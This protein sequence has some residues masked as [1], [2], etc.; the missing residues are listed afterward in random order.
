VIGATEAGELIGPTKTLALLLRPATALNVKQMLA[1]SGE[2]EGWNE[3]PPLTWIS[4]VP[5]PEPSA[6]SRKILVSLVVPLG[7]ACTSP[8]A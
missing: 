3:C 5:L 4:A 7:T 6:G 1:P 2:I 8:T